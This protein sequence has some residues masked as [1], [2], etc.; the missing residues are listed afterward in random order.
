MRR[1]PWL[2][3]P[4]LTEPKG[5]GEYY[6]KENVKNKR[7]EALSPLIRYMALAMSQTTGL[8]RPCWD[9]TNGRMLEITPRTVG[10]AL[11]CS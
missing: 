6:N 1:V 4:L 10:E 5:W 3:N 7:T 2:S 9:I 8:V 11:A